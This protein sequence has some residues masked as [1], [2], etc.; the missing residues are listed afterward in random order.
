MQ[1]VGGQRYDRGE[2]RKISRHPRREGGGGGGGGSVVEILPD[3]PQRDIL[4]RSPGRC[5]IRVRKHE[6]AL[7]RGRLRREMR[8]QHVSVDRALR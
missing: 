4:A 6:T 2:L 5:V 8:H 7:D 3:I 1:Q